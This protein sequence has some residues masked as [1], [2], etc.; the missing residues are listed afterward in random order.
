M[1]QQPTDITIVLHSTFVMLYQAF[2]HSFNQLFVLG[3]S[4]PHS[5]FHEVKCM[6]LPLGKGVLCC[7]GSVLWVIALLHYEVP[8]N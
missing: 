3:I 1:C 8:P 6:L 7:V 5:P 4:S 2:Y